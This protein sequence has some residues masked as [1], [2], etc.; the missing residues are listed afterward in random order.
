MVSK[1]NVFK[2][3][4][5]FLFILNLGSIPCLYSAHES[6]STLN[7][8]SIQKPVEFDTSIIKP[9]Q[10]DS[11]Y[12][13]FK[14][15]AEPDLW[16]KFKRWLNLQWNKFLDW[17]LSGIES[18]GVWEYIALILKIIVII[19]IALL[20]IWLF[21]KYYT[22]RPKAPN[23]NQ[24][25]V[26]L[27]EEEE[28]LIQKDLSTLAYEAEKDNNYRLASRYWF[29]NLLKHLKEKHFIDYQF[30]KTNTDYKNELR[31]TRLKTDFT[32]AS[33]FYE[34]VW[35][36][37]FKLDLDEFESAKLKFENIINYIKTL[38]SNE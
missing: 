10:S 12:Y 21:N 25:Q 8:G 23:K 2:Y 7:D 14:A 11:D 28:L 18:G 33:R 29:L 34:F 4:V 20:I 9:Y 35:Y 19:G 3:W 22:T 6:Y 37:D 32:Y 1:K 31:E 27:S 26:N 13:Y 15:E 30:Q 16:Q 38:K 36:G 24:S 17:L 5:C